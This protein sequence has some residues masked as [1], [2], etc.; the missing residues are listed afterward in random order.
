MEQFPQIQTERLLLNQL[1]YTDIPQIVTYAANKRISDYTLNL[2]YPYTDE[3]AVFWIN[4][5][6]QGFKNKTN[7]IF[8]IRIKN[9]NS[10]IGGIGL[11]VEQRFNRAELGYWIAEPFWN[12][13]YT[14]EA[15]KE[16]I[17]FG[18][19]K[20]CL[21]KI[22]SSHLEENSASGKVMTKNGMTLEGTLKEHVSKQA[23]YHN[24]HVYGLTKK[25]YEQQNKR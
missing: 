25:D 22:T 9:D 13:G 14:T 20:L 15:A 21:N 12:K 6:N 2:P 11:T 16:M 24:L 1:Q 8:A 23:A 3:D 7:F 18:F 10:F 17:H 5:A 4:L 19:D